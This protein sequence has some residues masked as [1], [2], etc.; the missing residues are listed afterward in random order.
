MTECGVEGIIYAFLWFLYMRW[1]AKISDKK[2]LYW[3]RKT[4]ITDISAKEITK[5]AQRTEH[6]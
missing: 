4:N 5:E 3:P 6:C 2:L 1:E